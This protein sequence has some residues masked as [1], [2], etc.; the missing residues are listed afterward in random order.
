MESKHKYKSDN[1]AKKSCRVV[2]INTLGGRM[3]A[4][5]VGLTFV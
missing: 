4:E 1:E 3:S 5:A 2:R